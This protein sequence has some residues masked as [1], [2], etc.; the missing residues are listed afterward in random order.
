[1]YNENGRQTERMQIHLGDMVGSN[2]DALPIIVI[3]PV[4]GATAENTSVFPVRIYDLPKLVEVA[5][6]IIAVERAKGKDL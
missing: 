2:G 3:A 4:F 5:N 1:M 6:R